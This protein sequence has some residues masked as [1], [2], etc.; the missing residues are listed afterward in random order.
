MLLLSK[1]AFIKLQWK[2]Q[3][4]TGFFIEFYWFWEDVVAG[5]KNRQ[6]NIVQPQNRRKQ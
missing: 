2:Y 4:N 6:L 5:G 3:K 1:V